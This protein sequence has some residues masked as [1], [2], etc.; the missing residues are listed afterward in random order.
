LLYLALP[1]GLLVF[2]GTEETKI[3]FHIFD[4]HQILLIIDWFNFAY[5]KVPLIILKSGPKFK[6]PPN[7]SAGMHAFSA[8][9]TFKI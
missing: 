3:I 1:S 9:K 7:E 2:F 5:M 4:L 8:R 6:N